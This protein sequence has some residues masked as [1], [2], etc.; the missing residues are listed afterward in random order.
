[1]SALPLLH[2]VIKCQRKQA[3]RLLRTRKMVERL[4]NQR[5][6]GHVK[7]NGPDGLM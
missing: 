3:V 1:M 4:Q 5:N 7:V 6:L 2:W